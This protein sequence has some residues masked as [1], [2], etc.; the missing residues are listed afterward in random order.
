MSRTSERIFRARLEFL[1]KER[2]ASTVAASLG[3]SP[4]T[5]RRWQRGIQAPSQSIREKVRR[6][7]LTAG[8][9][10]ARQYRG[11]G[12]GQFT[13]EGTVATGGSIRAVESVNRYM[14]RI[15][16]AEMRR[17][18]RSGDERQIEMARA[19]PTRLSQVEE[20]DLSL[21]REGLIDGT[22]PE[23][24]WGQWR[25]DYNVATGRA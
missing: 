19:L 3:R 21:R 18:R 8:A 4:S 2:G 20:A 24:E 11:E 12:Q 15:R 14:R 13:A 22:L 9:A 10:R 25:V 1:I 5:V 16:T 6:R 17:A 7:G 23:E